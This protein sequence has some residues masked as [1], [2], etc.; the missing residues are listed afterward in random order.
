MMTLCLYLQMAS[1]SST[2]EN[3]PLPRT[4][5]K[6]PTKFEGGASSGIH[7]VIYADGCSRGISVLVGT[8]DARDEPQNVKAGINMRTDLMVQRL[9]AAFGVGV[10]MVFIQTISLG[11]AFGPFFSSPNTMVLPLMAWTALF[12]ILAP[13]T[14]TWNA[15]LDDIEKTIKAA[16]RG[17]P[18]FNV[19]LQP[20]LT[21]YGQNT[22]AVSIH[23]IHQ[24][25]PDL[26]LFLKIAKRVF[27]NGNSNSNSNTLEKNT[28]FYIG[29]CE[30]STNASDWLELPS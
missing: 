11:H 20:G 27:D 12:T 5:A 16:K 4:V 15:L 2:N 30:N 10:P 3:S 8:Y 17:G 1:I 29:F 21:M 26:S 6:V 9:K 13:K 19:N 23:L 22:Q 24:I 18:C 14:A 25:M 7:Q 28:K